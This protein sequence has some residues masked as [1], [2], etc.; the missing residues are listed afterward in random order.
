MSFVQLP[1][2]PTDW[3]N[4]SFDIYDFLY[5]I[6]ICICFLHVLW[7]FEDKS[8][9][10]K[11]SNVFTGASSICI[12][13]FSVLFIATHDVKYSQL[14]HASFIAGMVMDLAYGYFMF[15]E[16]MYPLTTTFHHVAYCMIEWHLVATGNAA[17]FSLYFPQEFP[18]FLLGLKRYF[19]IRSQAYELAFGFCYFVFRIVYFLYIS[20]LVRGIILED[21][22]FSG[23]FLLVAVLHFHWFY[24][25]SNK[26]LLG[27]RKVREKKG[28]KIF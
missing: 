20:Y 7:F 23:C 10:Q 17:I 6:F 5:D 19:L 27:G 4:P 13:S 12:A 1:L 3:M 24:D 14:S 11:A 26:N 16:Y 21:L 22:F 15:P 8:N 18:T 28:E 9:A 25:W 2:D